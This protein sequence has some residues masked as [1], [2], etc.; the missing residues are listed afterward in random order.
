MSGTIWCCGLRR[1]GGVISHTFGRRSSHPPGEGDSAINRVPIS[2][3]TAPFVVLCL[4]WLASCAEGGVGAESAANGRVD[5]GPCLVAASEVGR[6]G[7]VRVPENP[8]RPGGRQIDLRVVILPARTEPVETDPV[9]LLAGGPGMAATDLARYART[10]LSEAREH[11]DVVLVDQRGTGESNP[12]ACDLYRDARRLQPYL[13]PM[14]PLEPVERCRER[15]TSRADL[16]QYTTARS[17]DDLD[18]VRAALG[19]RQINLFGVSYGSRLALVYLRRHSERVRRVVVQG[20]IP[21]EAPILLAG[22]WGGR[23]ALAAAI[24]ACDR[25]PRC[26]AEIPNPRSDLERLLARLEQQPERLRIWNGRRLSF[27]TVTLRR[28]GIE[29]RIWSMLYSPSAARR[30]LHLVHQAAE[31]D[32][33]PLVREALANSRARKRGRSEGLM[34]SVLCAEDAPRLALADALR[35]ST[36][37]LFHAP[38]ALELVRA[39]RDWPA[40]IVPDGFA[41]PVRSDTPILLLSGALDPVTPPEIAATAAR[42]LPDAIHLVNP[43]GGHAEADACT[44]EVIGRFLSLAR[45]E[46]IGRTCMPH[47][48]EFRPSMRAGA[49][50]D[51]G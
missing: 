16:R 35:D 27:E 50:D 10:L 13:E 18:F 15:L 8:S 12:L 46:S 40:G 3:R 22:S 5:L 4:L 6:C 1:P 25:D 43:Q 41:T 42:H 2:H 32:V 39:C 7:T 26:S 34:L 30:A 28:R 51:S 31:G 9:F 14:F 47:W 21:P 17:A 44:R 48:S 23:R 38:V 49:A 24:A 33:K 19:Y 45:G 11:R 20:V 29:E 37:E 36:P